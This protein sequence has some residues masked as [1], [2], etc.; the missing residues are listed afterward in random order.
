MNLEFLL[1]PRVWCV[2]RELKWG[3]RFERDLVEKIANIEGGPERISEISDRLLKMGLVYR[4]R[5]DQGS[6]Y[7]CL[8]DKGQLVTDRLIEVQDVLESDEPSPGT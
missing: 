8:T 7:L 2:L 6:P 5:G 1:Q 4:L 3:D